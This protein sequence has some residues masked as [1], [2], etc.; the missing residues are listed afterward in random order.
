MKI[1]KWNT[2][3]ALFFITVLAI[4]NFAQLIPTT[5][6]IIPGLVKFSDLG[7]IAIII[8]FLWSYF[9]VRTRKGIKYEY[10]IIIAALI[11]LIII[12][13]YVAEIKF[14]QSIFIGVR[15]MRT[16]I[17]CFLL[18]FPVT[19]M[20]SIGQIKYKDFIKILFL[21][22]VFELTV[23]TLQYLLADT[24]TF[25][26][27]DTTEVRYNSTR[28]RVPYLL[29]M[30]LGLYCYD[31][32]LVGRANNLRKKLC[33]ALMMGGSIF[34]LF[35]VC[36]H[37][38]PSLILV[39]T[40]GLGYLLWKKN[41]SVKFVVG[42][43]LVVL[44]VVFLSNSDIFL[45]AING[46]TNLNS[47]DNTLRVREAGQL[48]YIQKI[49]E[50]PIFGYGYPN[51]NNPSAQYSAGTRYNF[52]ILDNGV[53]GFTYI[54]GIAGVIWLA[55]MFLKSYRMSFALYRNRISYFFLLYFYYETRNM[56]IGMH[57]Y[58][59]NPLPFVLVLILLEY[60]YKEMNN[61]LYE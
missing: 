46:L 4:Q 53:I 10:S 23:Y 22:G 21:V 43:L 30:V 33:N 54:Q 29:P 58:F 36:K 47:S 26:Y 32:I 39:C 3:T 42:A 52:F 11:I 44:T 37:R 6:Y 57:W 8:F 48:Y 45:S 49:S 9:G 28:L 20:L 55:F 19:R 27:I 35:I 61:R 18:Y 40:I 60:N 38:A 31:S 13:S 2:T 1:K 7:I 15:S 5:S 14:D 16:L 41:F 34:L 24:I 17:A 25:L 50:S 59:L 12:S 51:I 56:Y